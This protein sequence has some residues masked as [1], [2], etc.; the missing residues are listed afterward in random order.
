MDEVKI[1][2]EKRKRPVKG[3][4]EFVSK[5]R[6][7][8]TVLELVLIGSLASEDPYPNDIDLAIFLKDLHDVPSIA[9]FARQISSRYHGWEVFVFSYD[10][11]YFGRICHRRECPANSIDCAVSG[12]GEITHIQV[13]SEF[14]F[15]PQIFLAS[16]FRI[17][18]TRQNMSIFEDWRRK[19]N[20]TGTT[21][22]R[23][24]EPIVKTCIDCG[25]EFVY[26]V[27]EQKIFSKR[28]FY[29]PKRCEGCR[30]KKHLFLY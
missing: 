10:L 28:G 24:L 1:N 15:N 17:L 3:V 19:L 14:V 29:A 25:K 27:A 5:M 21:F 13:N 23:G 9:K 16:P 7:L 26:S 4:E 18:W 30:S 20:I 2:L 8:P 22:P 11:K 6:A 12:C